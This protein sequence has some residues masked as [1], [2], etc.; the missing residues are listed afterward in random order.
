VNQYGLPNTSPF[1]PSHFLHSPRSSEGRR[2][3]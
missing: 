1:F 3:S 2:F